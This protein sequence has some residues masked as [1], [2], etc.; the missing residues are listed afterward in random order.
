MAK[1]Q[2]FFFWN[3]KFLENLERNRKYSCDFARYLH[4]GGVFSRSIRE[5][6]VRF[7]HNLLPLFLSKSET[8]TS[9]EIKFMKHFCIDFQDFVITTNKFQSIGSMSKQLSQWCVQV[10]GRIQCRSFLLLT[11]D[12]TFLRRPSPG[13]AQP[14]Q[15]F[16]SGTEPVSVYVQQAQHLARHAIPLIRA[17]L[18]RCRHQPSFRDLRP[19]KTP[20]GPEFEPSIR[21][22]AEDL[23]HLSLSLLNKYYQYIQHGM[24]LCRGSATFL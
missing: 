3:L 13:I 7:L 4:H 15:P 24:A 17:N 21:S 8:M 5:F 19:G 16:W 11:R 2:P 9:L 20:G 22:W 14:L 18:Y 10:L 23:Q 1:I 12:A 6:C